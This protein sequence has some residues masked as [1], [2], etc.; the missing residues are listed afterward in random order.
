MIK[1]K[2]DSDPLNID[3]NAESGYSLI[4]FNDDVN[5]FEFVIESLVE[6]CRLVPQQAHQCALITHYKGK[7]EIKK[8]LLDDLKIMCKGLIDKNLIAEIQTKG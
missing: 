6:I 8:G 1:E 3:A 7:C 2:K 4:L 5:D